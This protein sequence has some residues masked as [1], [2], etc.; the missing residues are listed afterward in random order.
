MFVRLGLP[1]QD[2][3][4]SKLYEM[5]TGVL[6]NF[7]REPFILFHEKC[8]VDD[9][10]LWLGSDCESGLDRV[11]AG[12]DS[13]AAARRRCRGLAASPGMRSHRFF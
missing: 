4:S 10:A 13:G 3:G 12:A 5:Y 2:R 7:S 6:G 1:L 8:K 9:V 11:A